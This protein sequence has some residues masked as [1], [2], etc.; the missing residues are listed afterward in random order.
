MIGATLFIIGTVLG[1]FFNV[2]IYRVPR[3]ESVVRPPSACPA[4]G[5]RLRW[6]ENIPILGYVF[7]R[8][9][10][11]HCGDRISPR[12]IVVEFLAGA[13]PVLLYAHF[14]LGREFLVYWPL[15]YVLLVLSFIASSRTR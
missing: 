13:L 15:S 4:C 12:Y 5:T 11:H 8:G 9:R 7:L 14:G 1:S 10:C 6:S 2:V 3:G